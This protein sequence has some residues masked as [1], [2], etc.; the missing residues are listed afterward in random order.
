MKSNYS[1]E[2]GQGLV[3]YALILGLVAIIVMGILA[4]LG[5]QVG[6][7]FSRITVALSVSSGNSRITG[8]T[9]A[10]TGNGHGNDLVVTVTVS[11]NTTVSVTDSQSGQSFSMSCSGSCQHTMT[12][13]GHSAGTVTATASGSSMSAGYSAKH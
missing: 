5:P 6:D 10:R 9:A 13:V 7:V 2:K 1:Q 3:E 4:M 11:E 8:V 12:G